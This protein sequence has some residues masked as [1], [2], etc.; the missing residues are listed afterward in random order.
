VLTLSQKERDR[1]VILHQ[2]HQNQLSLAEGAKRARLGLRH[3]RRLVRRFEVEGDRALAHGLRGRP[4][5]HRLSQSLRDRALAKAREPLYD[6]FGALLLSEHLARDPEIGFIHPDTLRLWMT[7]DGLWKP[8]QRRHPHRRRRERRAARGELVLMD[9]SIHAWL[10]DRSD[11]EIVLIALIDDAT[12]RLHARFFPRDTGAANRQMIAHYLEAEGRMGALYVDRASHFRANWKRSA[13]EAHDLDAGI[14]LIQRALAGLEIEIIFALSPQA[15]GRVERLFKTLQ[16]RLIKE[17]R[18]AGI[19]SR[20]DANRFLEDVFIPFWNLRFSVEARE[21]TDAHRALPEGAD[22]LCLFAQTEQRVI[23]A[24]FTFRYKN[25][26]FQIESAHAHP[27][28]PTRKIVVERRHDGS[29][30]FRSQ[31]HYLEPTPIA[32]PPPPAPPQA[33]PQAPGPP[34]SVQPPVPQRRP[35]AADH[36]WRRFPIKVGR[37]YSIPV[38]AALEPQVDSPP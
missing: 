16:D 4:S 13:R 2:V 35:P 28:M 6:D 37:G 5:N 27:S 8:K 33:P 19:C 20:E 7:Q 29:I 32:P 17:M 3:F 36:P 10:E 14:T 25:Q 23:R 15:K 18:V 24:D 12:S 31:D 11:E 26:H 34:A 21:S 22:L 9:T 30:R 1:L 38:V